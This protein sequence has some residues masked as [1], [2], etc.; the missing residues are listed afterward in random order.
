[1]VP[2]SLPEESRGERARIQHAQDGR[3]AR[4]QNSQ[5]CLSRHYQGQRSSESKS[6]LEL[7]KNSDRFE[8]CIVLSTRIS[9][10]K[11]SLSPGKSSTRA[12][13]LVV[14]ALE[15]GMQWEETRDTTIHPRLVRLREAGRR[16]IGTRKRDR[17]EK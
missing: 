16:E 11:F 7:I 10:I 15:T 1:M 9:M 5:F 4:A 12:L 8:V 2:F 6:T 14:T 17:E 13:Q 3:E